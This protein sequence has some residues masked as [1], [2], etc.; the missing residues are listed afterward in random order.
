MHE[1]ASGEANCF[2]NWLIS[3]WE[4]SCPCKAGGLVCLVADSWLQSS[5]PKWILQSVP[6]KAAAC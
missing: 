3:L 6:S 5:F 4:P 1:L 2:L